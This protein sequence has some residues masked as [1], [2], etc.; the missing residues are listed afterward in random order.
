M[1]WLANFYLAEGPG[2][3]KDLPKKKG[4]ALIGE[5]MWREGYELMKLNL[6]FVLSALPIITLPA[7]IAALMDVTLTIAD[8]RNVY[9]WDD[10]K[11]AFRRH[12]VRSSA[13]AVAA[14]PILGIPL[15]AAYVYGGLTLT[16]LFYAP[17]FVLAIS[18]V[19]FLAIATTY[20]VAFVAS[21][22]RPLADLAILAF[23]AALARPLHVLAA[24]A[25][26]AALWLAHI[27]FY[28]VSLFLPAVVN[29]SFGALAVAFS[30]LEP[31]K[32]LF[33]NQE[34]LLR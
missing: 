11:A 27:L 29:F 32:R 18:V 26:I 5:T 30:V 16:S 14:T 22:Q 31:V 6:I 21:S 2:I 23:K 12:F 28:P 4:L 9:L 17:A 15:Y 34:E 8:D 24:F 7:A 19:A 10:Y 20:L 3:P 33:H 25:F 1:K 13:I